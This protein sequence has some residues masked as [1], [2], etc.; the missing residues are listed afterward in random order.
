VDRDGDG[1]ISA[2]DIFALLAM[3]MQR[4]EIFLRV[5]AVCVEL[6]AVILRDERRTVARGDGWW[7]EAMPS[8]AAAAG[9]F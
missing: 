1:F 8:Y 5:R 2:D 7:L 6:C 3:L 9:S 4:S